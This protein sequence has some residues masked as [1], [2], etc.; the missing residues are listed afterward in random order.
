MSWTDRARQSGRDQ[1]LRWDAG[2]EIDVDVVS[3]PTEHDFQSK[4]GK[5]V[6]AFEWQVMVGG[7]PKVMSVTSRRL[8]MI[9]ADEEDEA[10][11]EGATLR[12]KAMGSGMD[13]QW[14]VRRLQRT[15]SAPTALPEEPDEEEE[16]PAPAPKP[17]QKK[18]PAPAVVECESIDE[19]EEAAARMRPA[20]RRKPRA[21]PDEDE[22]DL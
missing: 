15:R 8:L 11:I 17:V 22:D 1:Y 10:P 6:H 20:R 7:T 9:L 18:G 19:M 2:Q 13:R 3:G 12:I 4:D 21:D 16:A 14:R 5:N